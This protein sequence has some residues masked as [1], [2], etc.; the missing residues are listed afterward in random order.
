[1]WAALVLP[2]G[3]AGCDEPGELRGLPDIAVR[4][5]GDDGAA[6]GVASDGA[7]GE[8]GGTGATDAADGGAPE[9]AID[10]P[11]EPGVVIRVEPA[12]LTFGA[13]PVG[14]SAQQVVTVRHA[15]SEGVIEITKVT[16]VTESTDLTLVPPTRTELDAGA[17]AEIAVRYQPTDHEPDS[18]VLRI[19]HNAPKPGPE[20][21]EVPVRTLRLRGSLM[22]IPN[23]ASFGAVPSGQTDQMRIE[24]VNAGA[25]NL[26]IHEVELRSDSSEGFAVSGAVGAG[27]HPVT[28]PSTLA[29]AEELFVRATYTPAGPGDD[30]GTLVVESDDPARPVTEV[31]LLGHGVGAEM[32]VLPPVVDL[33]FVGTGEHAEAA[34]RILNKGN[35]ALD[36]EEVKLSSGSHEKLGLRDLPERLPVQIAPEDGLAFEVVFDPLRSFGAGPQSVGGVVVRTGVGE[37]TVPVYASGREPLLVVTPADGVDFGFTAYA[38]VTERTVVLFNGGEA[39]LEIG[40]ITIEDD[41]AGEFGVARIDGDDDPSFPLV[42]ATSRASE[43]VVTYENKTGSGGFAEALLRIESNDGARPTYELELSARRPAAGECKV[44]FSPRVLRFGDVAPGSSKTMELMLINFGSGDCRIPD[45]EDPD[46]LRVDDCAAA[47]PGSASPGGVCTRGAGTTSQTSQRFQATDPPL[48][49]LIKPG[50]LVSMQVRFAPPADASGNEEGSG[51]YQALV[52]MKV[53]DVNAEDTEVWAPAEAADPT[54]TAVE[55]N[56]TGAAVE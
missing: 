20:A 5:V 56:L 28:L 46:R 54:N 3:V 50:E 31:K 7:G 48:P 36:L 25:G 52:S 44:G 35:D 16:L 38:Q 13:V 23:P 43:L 30:V 2:V 6:A 53:F 15:G 37:L 42:I 39:A 4:V 14:S 22:V 49:A 21:L 17:S 41:P 34:V 29:P 32:A 10:V 27:G 1:M 51:S 11:P 26:T 19:A 8:A 40:R 12:E 45:L 9:V 47:N 55:P 33:G 18:G 24:L